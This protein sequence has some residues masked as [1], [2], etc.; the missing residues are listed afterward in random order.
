MPCKSAGC[1]ALRYILRMKGARGPRE[2]FRSGT[3]NDGILGEL[4][5][6]LFAQQKELGHAVEDVVCQSVLRAV[7]DQRQSREFLKQAKSF[8]AL[9]RARNDAERER[10]RLEPVGWGLAGVLAA[11]VGPT[12]GLSGHGTGLAPEIIV[13]LSA[14]CGARVGWRRAASAIV[15]LSAGRGFTASAL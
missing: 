14:A 15:T 11:Y 8:D 5:K 2:E 10:E 3:S 6:E 1:S 13:A 12:L 9:E 4:A 7:D